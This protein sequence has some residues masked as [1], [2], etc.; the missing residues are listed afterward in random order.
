MEGNDDSSENEDPSYPV[1]D[2]EMFCDVTSARRQISVMC[3]W[4]TVDNVG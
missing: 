2:D 1:D 4:T 3:K